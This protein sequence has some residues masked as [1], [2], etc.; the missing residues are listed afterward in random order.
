MSA[1]AEAPAA[2]VCPSEWPEL[3]R[4]RPASL[5][6]VADEV[7]LKAQAIA[8]ALSQLPA[9]WALFLLHDFTEI[10]VA[11]GLGPR[12][13][14]AYVYRCFYRASAAQSRKVPDDGPNS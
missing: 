10:A 13:V 4:Q 14:Y 7:A 1:A 9:A 2:Y 5:V 11:H 3:E 8:T 6:P 12:H